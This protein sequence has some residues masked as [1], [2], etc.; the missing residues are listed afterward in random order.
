VN[1]SV[2]LFHGS[3]KFHV[4]SMAKLVLFHIKEFRK[5]SFPIPCSVFDSS[6][7]HITGILIEA[8]HVTPNLFSN[9]DC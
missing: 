2:Y 9:M 3:V 4:T 7:T 1:G 5:D 6:I 8:L